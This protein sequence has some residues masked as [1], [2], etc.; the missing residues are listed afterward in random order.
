MCIRD[1]VLSKAM[2][3]LMRKL[4]IVWSVL[5][6]GLLLACLL[7]PL[8]TVRG[9]LPWVWMWPLLLWSE[10]GIRATRYR[11]DQLLAS[12]PSPLWRQLPAT[13]TAG[14]LLAFLS[15]SGAFIRLWSEPTLL[16]GFAA[17]ALFIPSLSL[18]LGLAAGTE[19]PTQL[20][21]LIWWYLGPLNGLAAL[22]LTGV[23]DAAVAQGVPWIYLA[24][25]PL[26]FGLALLVRQHQLQAT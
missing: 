3:P 14:V 21:L 16:P 5:L 8:E 25:S 10:L 18:L 19:R 11:V 22:D 12:A 20:L 9:L 17:G 6:L 13:W 7:S 1:R 23:T 24:S 4:I 15:G 26:L 2:V